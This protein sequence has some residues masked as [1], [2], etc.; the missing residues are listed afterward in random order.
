MVRR[1]R[2]LVQFRGIL[3]A[4]SHKKWLDIKKNSALKEP[5]GTPC[6]FLTVFSFLPIVLLTGYFRAFQL[7]WKEMV[8]CSPWSLNLGRASFLVCDDGS[9][10]RR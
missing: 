1:V 3:A 4:Y 9:E 2:P 7:W 10:M 6:K 5:R 8:S